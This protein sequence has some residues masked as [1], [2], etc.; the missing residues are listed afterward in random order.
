MMII[1]MDGVYFELFEGPKA[2]MQQQDFSYQD[3][4]C[5]TAIPIL[6]F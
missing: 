3:W 4:L 1:I 5:G 6:V 2:L